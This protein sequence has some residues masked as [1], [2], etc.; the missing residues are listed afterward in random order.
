MQV[1][2]GRPHMLTSNQRGRGKEPVV[3]LGRI[4]SAVAVN[5]EGSLARAERGGCAKKRVE[6]S[7]DPAGTRAWQECL[8]HGGQL[9]E[10]QS[11]LIGP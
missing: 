3:V 9:Y 7:L 5:T 1:S 4:R 10:P 2:S 6:T 11:S 8:R